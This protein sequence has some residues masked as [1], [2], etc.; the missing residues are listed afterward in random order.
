MRK[1]DVKKEKIR[2]WIEIIKSVGERERDILPVTNRPYYLFRGVDG[3][4]RATG[5]GAFRPFCNV[6]W[7]FQ[8]P[9]NIP[10]ISGETLIFL[11]ALPEPHTLLPLRPARVY[12]VH[13]AP[14]AL[15]RVYEEDPK[16]NILN[17]CKNTFRPS[18]KAT[19]LRSNL[20]FIV[21]KNR[22]VSLP[23][24]KGYV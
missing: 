14:R 4:S 7:F 8:R 6:C 21:M 23:G 18:P 22:L 2:T 1:D 19:P 20:P 10:R 9:G 5:R 11:S 16:Q 12:R 24:I 13:R 17:V 3:V 15:S